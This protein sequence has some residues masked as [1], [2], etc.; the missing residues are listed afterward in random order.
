MDASSADKIDDSDLDGRG[1][2]FYEAL[3]SLCTGS[4]NPLRKWL[5]T[6]G[7]RPSE[8]WDSAHVPDR[9]Q[10]EVTELVQLKDTPGTLTT[11]HQ[12]RAM[13]L[14]VSLD[15]FGT[16]Y[17]SLSDLHSFPFDKIKIVKS[18]V[19]EMASNAGS[20]SNT[21]AITSL[22]HGL[23]VRTMAEGVETREQ[24]DKLRERN[25]AKCRGSF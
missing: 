6:L 9:L 14:A 19:R 21:R 22:G 11:L 1:R 12:L 20:V 2:R 4:S 13:G 10:L 23:G 25:A 8:R 5:A 24:M 3:H 18:F 15:D 17:S 7:S 16:G